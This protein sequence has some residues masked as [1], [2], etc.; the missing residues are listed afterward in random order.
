MRYPKLPLIHEV[1]TSFGTVPMLIKKN[2]SSFDDF[3]KHEKH[4]IYNEILNIFDDILKGN[5]KE[6]KLLVIARI[7]GVIFN[8]D[9][10]INRNNTSLLTET[11]I[12]YFEQL[13]EYETCQ[14][15][16]ELLSCLEV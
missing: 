12:P 6:S 9:F 7:D 10:K 4:N 5:I 15:V 2:Y 14:R 11:I 16:K 3:Y 13:E 8:T 1:K